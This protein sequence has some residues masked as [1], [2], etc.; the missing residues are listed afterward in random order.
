MSII[1]EVCIKT[2]HRQLF[3]A[4]LKIKDEKEAAAFLRDLLTN[5]KKM[6]Y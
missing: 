4:I 5:L 2:N 6:L 1:E 3:Q